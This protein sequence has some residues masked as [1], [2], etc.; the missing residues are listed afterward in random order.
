[1]LAVK[2]QAVVG[3]ALL[4]LGV[5]SWAHWPAPSLPDGARAD[6]V[7]VRKSARVLEL[8]S[9][10]RLLKAYPVSLGR[11]P[12]GPKEREGDRRTPEG[13]YVL[14]YRK[15]DSSFHRALHISYPTAQDRARARAL[16]VSPGG[17][18]MVHGLR[19]G[20]G[21]LGRLHLT[22]DWTDGCIAV[23]DVQIREI[24][25]AVPDRTPILITP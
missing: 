18:V 2:T 14:D 25:S 9:E 7:V 11:S 12:Q 1:M 6:R 15:A 22:V 23:T 13:E 16:G 24:W 5:G 21:W 10:G 20:L 8:Y 17:L 19:N 4:A 3:V